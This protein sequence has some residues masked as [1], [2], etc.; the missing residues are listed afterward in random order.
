LREFSNEDAASMLELNSDP[1]V[2]KFTGDKAFSSLDEARLFLENYNQY[3]LYGFGRW[4]VIQKSSEKFIG[5]CGLKYSATTDEVDIGFR[6]LKTVWNQGY[7]TEAAQ[8][9]INLG[10]ETF[11]IKRIVGRAMVENIASVKVLE[12]LGLTY[13]KEFDFDGEEGVIYEIVCNEKEH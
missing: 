1:E 11:G 7:A 2:L 13:L 8:K 6:F 5:W 12:K 4:A 9:C 10:F 3:S